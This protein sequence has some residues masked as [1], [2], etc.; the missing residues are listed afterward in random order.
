MVIEVFGLKVQNAKKSARETL[1]RLRWKEVIEREATVL[2]KPNF[3]TAPRAG[4]T[5]DLDLIRGVVKVI[6]GRAGR[7]VVGETDSTGKDFNNFINDLNLGC[8]VINL[9]NDKTVVVRG[10]HGAYNLPELALRSK[11]VNL[12]ILKTHTLTKI[13]GAV[14]NLFGLIQ[15][16]DKGVFHWGIDGVLADLYRIFKPELNIL[17]AIYSMDGR[18]PL[19]GRIRQTRSLL[20]SRDAL[21][22]DCAACELVKLNPQKVGHLTTAMGGKKPRYKLVGSVELGEAFEIPDTKVDRLG[23]FLYQYPAMRRILKLAVRRAVGS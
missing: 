14:K 2:I 4:V 6:R 9:S 16:K 20:A 1:E 3:L 18:G 21:A 10:E 19:D 15:D 7:V 11:L 5:T 22:L 8:E 23:A 13:T 12:P 17:D